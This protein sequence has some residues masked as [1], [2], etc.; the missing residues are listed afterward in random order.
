MKPMITRAGRFKEMPAMSLNT[1]SPFLH[2]RVLVEFREYIA[3]LHWSPVAHGAEGQVAAHSVQGAPLGCL[4]T[5]RDN[6]RP[7]LD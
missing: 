2:P 6:A 4:G 1:P 5:K 3:S 7:R